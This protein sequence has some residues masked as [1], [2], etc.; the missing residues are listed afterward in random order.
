MTLPRVAPLALALALVSSWS[1]AEPRRPPG[2]PPP[3]EYAPPPPVEQPGPPQGGVCTALLVVR[4]TRGAA[5]CTIDERVTHAPGLLEYPCGGGPATATFGA[6]RFT[7]TVMNGAVN[8]GLSTRFHFSDGCD[9]ES[10]QTIQGDLG[11]GPMVYSYAEAPLPGQARC[12][13]ACRAWGAV[14]VRQ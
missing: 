7:G 11:G 12:A 13:N 8:L 9:W 2:A 3:M 1:A 10:V 6:S 5:G 14:T 4:R